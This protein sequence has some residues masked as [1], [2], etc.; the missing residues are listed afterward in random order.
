MAGGKENLLLFLESLLAEKKYKEASVIIDA[1]S[2]VEPDFY[3]D[4]KNLIYSFLAD[5]EPSLMAKGIYNFN[6]DT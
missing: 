5:Q 6:I 3:R 4:L 2:A 1:I